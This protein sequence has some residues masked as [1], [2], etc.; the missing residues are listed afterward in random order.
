MH[1]DPRLE[2]VM[3]NR[4][5]TMSAV[6]VCWN[7]LAGPAAANVFDTCSRDSGDGAIA[8]CTALIA[9]GELSDLDLAA[10]YFNRGITWYQQGAWDQAIEDYSEAIELNPRF[11]QAF[12]SRGNALD[13]K[14]EFDRAIEDYDR[15]IKLDPTYAKAFNN[16]ALVWDE[17][18][19]YDRAIQDYGRAIIL[20]PTYAQAFNNRG[21]AYVHKGEYDR[22]IRD[23][24]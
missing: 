6:I 19:Q 24:D 21:V 23:F 15:A 22:A 11:A 4:W 2:R 10:I 13:S 1:P 18:R 5:M 12:F 3:P 9:S 14:R 16:R 8:A 7:A 20:N 17:K